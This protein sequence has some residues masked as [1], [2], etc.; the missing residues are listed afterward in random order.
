[1]S[2]DGHV[3]EWNDACEGPLLVVMLRGYDVPA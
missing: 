3:R 1:M 2:H